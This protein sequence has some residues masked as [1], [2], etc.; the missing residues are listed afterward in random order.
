MENEIYIEIDGHKD[1]F[2]SNLG[3]VKTTGRIV[4]FYKGGTKKYP[5]RMMKL[6]KGRYLFVEMDRKKRTVHRL[7]ANHFIPN[8][9]NK[10]FVNHINGNK[11]DNRVENLEWVT[12]KE[13]TIHAYSKGLIPITNHKKV[14]D[15]NTG[16]IYA[17]IKEYGE[18]I[19][20]SEWK[21][22]NRFKKG[23]FKNIEL[24]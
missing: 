3:N 23:M 2:V 22:Y 11:Y 4:P 19:N 12:A 21:L 9:Q 10:P 8:P 13:N 14:I 1:Y 7:V 6:Q 5:E 18:N 24:I 15:K 16:K 17:S 20:L